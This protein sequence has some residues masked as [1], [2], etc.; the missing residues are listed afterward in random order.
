MKSPGSIQNIHSE[1]AAPHIPKGRLWENPRLTDWRAG[2]AGVPTKEPQPVPSK[3]GDTSVFPAILYT[4][5]QALTAIGDQIE[6]ISMFQFGT[7]R[8]KKLHS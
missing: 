3:A 7:L 5:Y 8:K 1:L 4:V 6:T 2:S